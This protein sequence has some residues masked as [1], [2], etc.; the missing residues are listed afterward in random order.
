MTT[1][2]QS[3]TAL[4]Q[5]LQESSR[6]IM[7]HDDFKETARAIY[8]ILKKYIGSGG[9]YV[10]LLS[11]DEK[12]N[13]LLF[14]DAGGLSCR[15][16]PT[17]P[18]PV[19]G[20]RAEAYRTGQVIYRNN[21]LESPWADFLPKNHARLENVLFA[22][23][24]IK[25]TVVGVI[26]LANK[27]GG[28]TEQDAQAAGIFGELAAIAFDKLQTAEHL[29]ISEEHFRAVAQTATDAI[30]STDREGRIIYWN[31][32]AEAL[33]GYSE[34]EI[35]GSPM[36]KLLPERFQERHAA[37]MERVRR[38]GILHLAGKT[39]EFIG[40]HRNGHELPIEISLSCWESNGGVYFTAII[41]D[42]TE[43]KK[44]E[45]E[46]QRIEEAQLFLLRCGY[47]HPGENFFESLARYL[48]QTLEM[49]YVRITRLE[50]DGLTARTVAIYFDAKFEDNVE[51]ALQDTPCGDVFGKTICCFPRGVRQLFPRDAVL[52]EMPAESYVGTTLWDF[53]GNP[54]GLIAMIGRKPLADPHL[55]ES[56]LRFV[57]L[58]AAGEL[59]RKQ[60]E[61]ALSQAQIRLE[62]KV[63]ERTAELTRANETLKNE[64]KTR[65]HMENALAESDRKFRAIFNQTFQVI[66]LLDPD[67]TVLEINQTALDY[68]HIDYRDSLG[69]PLWELRRE[70]ATETNRNIFKDA[71]A[72]AAKGQLV[73]FEVPILFAGDVIRTMDFSIKP[74]LSPGGLVPL[75]IIE[76][77][78]ITERKRIELTLKESENQQRLHSYQVLQA[79]EKERK[80][81]A[82]EL[83]D[84]I[85]QYLSAIKYRVEHLMLT[86]LDEEKVSSGSSSLE[87]VIPVIQGAIEE[88]RRICMDLRP[89]ILDDLGIL[90]TISW[91]C[92][93]FQT[94]YS[95]IRIKPRI[96]VQEEQIP[97]LLK[98]VIFRIIQEALNN[99]GK[100]SQAGQ[101]R[102]NLV[103][104][105]HHLQL[106][107]RDNGV[108]F[109][110]K[111]I[112]ALNGSTR[113]MGLA[114]MEERAKLSGGTF[115][116]RAQPG[117]GTRIQAAWPLEETD[118]G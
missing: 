3:P 46:R 37:A 38:D 83:H 35:L 16:D 57:A 19:R 47:L 28:F 30:I 29:K 108:G 2:D 75:L 109:D 31:F 44:G 61:E 105:D 79:Q 94:T 117:K 65:V 118:A 5:A 78:D 110:L 51:Y 76:G 68:F 64:I 34:P 11:K 36:G 49:D 81:I 116:I 22:P 15:M 73:R 87:N 42:I 40:K 99:I 92:R 63:L 89:S 115:A 18:M 72:Q 43:R 101:I 74:V 55:A 52:Q 69:K 50:N 45:T 80:R 4:L 96:Q 7:A 53:E 58:R 24:K 17:L 12:A 48:A 106:D 67:G 62:D 100:H 98:T 113:G 82:Q 60:A 1:Q 88:I 54:I 33:F 86:H 84:G 112:F 9:G 114:G 10:A 70:S 25:E 32:R 77:R 97:A 23:L 20:M 91:F 13:E 104:K 56:I 85:G 103:Q 95:D 90:A 21:F 26:G 66:G 71:I 102:L 107:I 14:L 27:P 39:M 8:T 59:E 41:R 6:Q 111:S 93:E